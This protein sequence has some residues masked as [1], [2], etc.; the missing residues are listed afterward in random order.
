M[1]LP[2]VANEGRGAVA[3]ALAEDLDVGCEQ[4]IDRVPAV[5]QSRSSVQVQ[6]PVSSFQVQVQ[7]QVQVQWWVRS[8]LDTYTLH[9][10]TCRSHSG[11]GTWT[12]SSRCTR[13][14]HSTWRRDGRRRWSAHWMRAGTTKSTRL[15]VNKDDIWSGKIVQTQ[16]LNNWMIRS[17]FSKGR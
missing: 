7:V 14:R 3:E 16:Y 2:I 5:R 1:L 8:T 6:C 12:G 17:A 10:C 4:E 9:C 13:C 15:L 11:S